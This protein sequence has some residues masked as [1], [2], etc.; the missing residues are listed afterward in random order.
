MVRLQAKFWIPLNTFILISF[1]VYGTE[2][3]FENLMCFEICLNVGKLEEFI[4]TIIIKMQD[5]PFC[6]IK[7][8]KL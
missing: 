8:L 6:T 2:N 4:Y 1:P 5:Q 3:F 7:G